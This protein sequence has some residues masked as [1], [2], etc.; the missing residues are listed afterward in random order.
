MERRVHTPLLEVNRMQAVRNLAAFSERASQVAPAGQAL[1]DWQAAIFGDITALLVNGNVASD[2]VLPVGVEKSAV[3]V[4]VAEVLNLRTLIVVR[5]EDLVRQT[6]HISQSTE[7]VRSQVTIIAHDSLVRHTKSRQKKHRRVFQEG[8]EILH[9]PEDIQLLLIDGKSGELTQQ[10]GQAISGFRHAITLSFAAPL[11]EAI[12]DN[13]PLSNR[14]REK[15]GL[16]PLKMSDEAVREHFGK[17]IKKRFGQRIDPER[18]YAFLVQTGKT[19]LI[20]E[21]ATGSKRGAHTAYDEYVSYL[22]KQRG[23]GM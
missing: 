4:A 15:L 8:R 10:H 2:V 1:P 6:E 17:T 12:A 7:E 14:Q 11:L 22:R 5:P 16:L 18:L 19:E 21:I 9:N 20:R 23:Q 3:F 13:G